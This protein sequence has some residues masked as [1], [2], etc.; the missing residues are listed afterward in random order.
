MS[1]N[2]F[3]RQEATV[4]IIE[5]VANFCSECYEEILESS[6]IFYDMQNFRYLCASCQ[7]EIEQNLE[8]DCELLQSDPNSLFNG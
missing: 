7:A 6:T 2:C 3:V 8:S 1:S 5:N 4:E